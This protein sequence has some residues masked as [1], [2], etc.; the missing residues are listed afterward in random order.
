MKVKLEDVIE[1]IE[2]ANESNKTYLNKSTG[3]IHLIPEEVDM[4]IRNEVFDENDLPDWE[5]EIIPIAKDIL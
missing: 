1:Q 2:F 5:K 4:Y 3:E